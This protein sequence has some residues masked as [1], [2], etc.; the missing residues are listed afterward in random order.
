MAANNIGLFGMINA[1]Y[2][3]MGVGFEVL[4]NVAGSLNDL[5]KVAKLKSEGYLKEEMI[6]QEEKLAN[7]SFKQQQTLARIAALK[8]EPI[9]L[10]AE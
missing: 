7:L 10:D 1:G 8:A 2:N 3:V 5:S 6:V 4:E 9:T